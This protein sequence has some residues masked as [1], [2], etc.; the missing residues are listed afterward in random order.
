MSTWSQIV[1]VERRI[2]VQRRGHRLP[3]GSPAPPT[4]Y[5]GFPRDRTSDSALGTVHREGV[6]LSRVNLAHSLSRNIFL[7]MLIHASVNPATYIGD[8]AIT[9]SNEN[10]FPVRVTNFIPV[11]W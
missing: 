2:H 9:L 5:V 8:T 3:R 11:S 1:R 7:V 10:A 4:G 6:L